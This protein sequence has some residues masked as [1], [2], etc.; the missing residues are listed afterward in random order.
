MRKTLFAAVSLAALATA[1]IATAQEAMTGAAGGAVAGAIVGGPI[2]AVVGG[3]IGGTVG[4][5]SESDR[6][7]N[8]QR[9]IVRE[10]PPG[11]VLQ[12]T[13]VDDGVQTKCTEAVR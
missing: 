3:V 12:R 4:A 8:E 11:A 10:Q 9:V 13:C 5:A 7:A 1:P 6:R 2:G